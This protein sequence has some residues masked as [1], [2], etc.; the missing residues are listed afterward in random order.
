[1][2]VYKI[3]EKYD[4]SFSVAKPLV[5]VISP[6]YNAESTISQT[7]ESLLCQTFGDWEMIIVDDCSTDMSSVIIENYVK[8]DCR[9][10]YLK[11]DRCS[12]SPALPRNL[13]ISEAKGRYIAFLDSDDMWLP[14]KLK[15]QLNIITQ[16]EIAIV[17]SNY[18]KIGWDSKCCGREIIAPSIVDYLLLLK[19]NCIGC[20]TAMYD[21]VKVGK[22]FFKKIGHEDYAMWL[23]IL[24]SGYKARNTDTVAALYRV[25]G[26]SISSNKLKTMLWQWSIL[27]NEEQLPI[28][29]AAYYFIHYMV[30]ALKKTIK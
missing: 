11:T 2:D 9:I 14:E 20:L 27:R 18:E 25:G 16:P 30:R 17:F 19:G 8:R 10:R 29:K 12:G 13:G 23:S 26:H 5:S 6:C 22:V 4:N 24:K 1:M 3:P 28:F 7:I 21:T 15:N